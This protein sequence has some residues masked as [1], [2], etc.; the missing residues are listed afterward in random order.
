MSAYQQVLDA[1]KQAPTVPSPLRPAMLRTE[2]ET[3]FVNLADGSH[4]QLL[5][6]DLTQG[7]WVVRMR[8][9]PGCAIERHYHTGPVYA[10]TLKGRWRYREYPDEVNE[11]GSYL[12]EPAGSVHTL[13]TMPGETEPAEVW[14][15][16]HGANVNIDE[17]GEVTSVLDA[18]SVLNIY[19][20]LCQASGQSAE[21]VIVFGE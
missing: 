5:Q 4:L 12:F 14:F 13:E 2:T 11:A 8:F 1:M 10:F 17:S 21:N 18:A 6:V 9:D 20:A 15:A 3:P 19:R 7:L 16:V